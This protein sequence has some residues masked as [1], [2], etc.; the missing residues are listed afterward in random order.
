MRTLLES[1]RCQ[2]IVPDEILVVD[3]GIKPIE[4]LLADFPQLNLRYLRHWPPSAAAQRNEGI[5]ACGPDA[6]LVGF[7]D[8]DTTF[9]PQAFEKMLAFWNDAAPDLLGAAFNMRNFPPRRG[10]ILKYSLFAEH[11]GL[12]SSKPGSVCPSGWQTV[13]GQLQETQFVDWVPSTAV[14]FRREVFNRNFFD[15]FFDDYSYLEDLDFSYTLSRVGRLAV[16]ACAGFS[17]FPSTSG[18]ISPRMFGRYEVRNRLYFVHKHR[19]STGRCYLGL[20]VRLA[21]SVGGGL[22]SLDTK[23]LLRALG[24]IEELIRQSLT[25]LT[26][27][28][29]MPSR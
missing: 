28:P 18:R 9:E 5:R 6:T 27:A 7:A 3:A 21:I 22:A 1:L 24:N 8:D 13:I 23:L 4:P 19:L 14:L 12:Y 10:G 29:L 16:V 11:L 26:A 25:P 2:T 15:E 20:I 17:H